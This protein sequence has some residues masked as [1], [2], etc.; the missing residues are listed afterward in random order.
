MT[1]ADLGLLQHARWRAL[2][3]V[4]YYHKALH[5]G[6]CGNP[7][8]ASAW[9]LKFDNFSEFQT[10]IGDSPPPASVNMIHCVLKSICESPL[11]ILKDIKPSK[12]FKIAHF[13]Y[14]NEGKCWSSLK[15]FSFCAYLKSVLSALVAICSI[16]K[17]L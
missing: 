9:T 14:K 4:N 5:L 15:M 1:E 6:C 7:R 16:L 13:F 11:N 3:A 2:W 17:M 10:V 12:S 8:S